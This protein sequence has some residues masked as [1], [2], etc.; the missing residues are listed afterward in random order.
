MRVPGSLLRLGKVCDKYMS[1]YSPSTC[2]FTE[3][4]L[5]LDT[6]R[7]PIEL[8]FKFQLEFCISAV[9][10]TYLVFNILKL[11]PAIRIY[12]CVCYGSYNKQ[13]FFTTTINRL[14]FVV[15]TKYFSYE[16]RI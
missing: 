2:R 4:K 10:F 1:Q 5:Y 11:Y 7:Y 13:L 12:F 16:V 15:K 14:L 6:L 9:Y 8:H 3:I